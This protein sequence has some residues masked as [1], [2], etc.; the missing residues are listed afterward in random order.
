MS[1]WRV[2]WWYFDIRCFVFSQDMLQSSNIDV[3]CVLTFF[4]VLA[5]FSFDDHVRFSELIQMSFGGAWEIT[6]QWLEQFFPLC[7]HGQI[8]SPLIMLSLQYN[9]LGKERLHLHE[10]KWTFELSLGYFQTCIWL[11]KGFSNH[12]GEIICISTPNNTLWCEED[13][14]SFPCLYHIHKD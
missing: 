4:K 10:S 8:K 11:H 7:H 3:N 12:K 2:V 9:N 6:M 14:C 1:N 5:S 13:K